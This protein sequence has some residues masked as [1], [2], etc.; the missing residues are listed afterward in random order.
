VLLFFTFFTVFPLPQAS[1]LTLRSIPKH[2]SSVNNYGTQNQ[3]KPFAQDQVEH[4]WN[5]TYN[6]VLTKASAKE[7]EDGEGPDAI[8]MLSEEAH[9]RGLQYALYDVDWERAMAR[10]RAMDVEQKMLD[11][12][13][14]RNGQEERVKELEILCSGLMSENRG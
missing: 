6:A 5:S 7:N 8:E 4:I 2:L 11:V 12:I 14:E 3:V 10:S 9:I 1:L 13:D